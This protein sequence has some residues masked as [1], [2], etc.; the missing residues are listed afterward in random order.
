M[1]KVK[2]I[3]NTSINI[4]VYY[5][6]CRCLEI[7]CNIIPQLPLYKIDIFACTMA[8][9]I[10]GHCKSTTSI[11]VLFGLSKNRGK[12]CIMPIRIISK[13]RTHLRVIE[14]ICQFQ[15]LRR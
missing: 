15:M 10:P 11:I 6:V 12:L 9:K 3:N 1:L 5:I 13:I 14:I 2:R 4:Y 7:R 8:R